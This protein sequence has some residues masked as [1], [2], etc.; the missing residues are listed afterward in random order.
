MTSQIFKSSVPN[1]ELF[2]LL[3]L[4][5]DKNDRYYILNH[6]A[7]KKGLFHNYINPFLEECVPH[8]HVSKTH[9]ITKKLTHKTFI[10]IIRQICKFNKIQFT[11]QIKYNKS[12]YDIIYYIY[13]TD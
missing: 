10:T 7:F 6:D 5:C 3:D 1:K 11:S 8:Y 13:F 4:I 9:Y 12:E 2:K